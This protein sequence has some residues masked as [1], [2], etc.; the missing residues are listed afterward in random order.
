MNIP[1]QFFIWV[2]NLKKV[3]YIPFVH[4]PTLLIKSQPNTKFNKVDL[5]EL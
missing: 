1:E 3:P 4:L 5:P 2:F